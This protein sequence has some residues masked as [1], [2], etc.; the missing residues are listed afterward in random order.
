V[1]PPQDV[2]SRKMARQA[3]NL[4]GADCCLLF[5]EK[6]WLSRPMLRIIL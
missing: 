3:K 1:D 2:M 5:K 4:F 6:E